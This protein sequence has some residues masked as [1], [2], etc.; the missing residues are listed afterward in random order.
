MK[1]Q[2]LWLL[3]TS[4]LP[5]LAGLGVSPV[6]A[7]PVTFQYS[8]TVVYT[9]LSIAGSISVGT[10][11]TGAITYETNT[12]DFSASTIFGE[13]LGAATS[14]SYS[15]GNLSGSSNEGSV[16][17]G[18]NSAN[19]DFIG[20]TFE[21]IGGSTF[22]GISQGGSL[23]YQF[24]L[25]DV[26][27]T[28]FSDNSLPANADF[29]GGGTFTGVSDQAYLSLFSSTGNFTG[30]SDESLLN[31]NSGVLTMLATVDTLTLTTSLETLTFF[32]SAESLSFFSGLRTEVVPDV[33]VDRV[34]EPGILALFGLGVAGLGWLNRRH[35]RKTLA[36]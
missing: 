30:L 5:A 3:A 28:A 17:V 27:G 13:Y 14:F 9:D 32:S 31:L 8:A 20:D 21:A 12:P 25:N 19:P 15:G 22:T 24:R 29:F 18:N 35:R 11:V 6:S 16:L 2:G 33:I 26:D 1:K 23:D 34:S 4:I 7:V 10:T 36:A